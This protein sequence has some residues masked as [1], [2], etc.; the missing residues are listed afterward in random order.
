MNASTDGPS[1][2]PIL[3]TPA[4]PTTSAGNSAS[5]GAATTSPGDGPTPSTLRQSSGTWQM[6]SGR[7]PYVGRRSVPM[8]VPGPGAGTPAADISAVDPT[9]ADPTHADPPEPAPSRVISPPAHPRR[10]RM[11]S[12]LGALAALILLSGSA[13]VL[14]RLV[15]Q[16]D[17]ARSETSAWATRQT[18][19]PMPAKPTPA[20]SS[21]A[22]SSG[23]VSVAPTQT[24]TPKPTAS[25]S[26]T[27]APTSSAPALSFEDGAF[28]LTGSVPELAVTV[29]ALGTEPVRVSAPNGAEPRVE[30]DGNNVRLVATANVG[31]RLAIQLN[32]RIAWAVRI[33]AGV[34]SASFAL[35]RATLSRLDL[36]GGATLLEM[37]LPAGTQA[38][39]IRMSGG[40]ETWRITTARPVPVRIVLRQGGGEV[41]LNGRSVRGVARNTTLDDR[42]AGSGA[43]GLDI[44][45]V[46]GLGTLTIGP[47][48]ERER[49]TPAPSSGVVRAGRGPGQDHAA[50]H[51]RPPVRLP[52][53]SPASTCLPLPTGSCA[54]TTPA[55]GSGWNHSSTSKR[56][57]GG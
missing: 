53:P 45:A 55:P 56:P 14:S 30:V 5:D 21:T 40:V 23:L 49:N 41:V 47:V 42:V 57:V 3:G 35:A 28:E 4:V 1:D 15:T 7:W 6:I 13:Q 44:E 20:M 52:H 36:T 11:R 38:I 39:P 32:E 48:G 24:P 18:V 9:H 25:A 54:A 16:P 12:L 27:K 22:P 50:R 51:P 34:Q 2:E 19:E 17:T 10:S 29:G 43:A 26:T 33:S 46:T 37:A 8:P 31:N